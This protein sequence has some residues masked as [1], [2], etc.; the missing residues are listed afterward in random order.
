MTP[1]RRSTPKVTRYRRHTSRWHLMKLWAVVLFPAVL[2]A[3]NLVVVG[4]GLSRGEVK[5]LGRGIHRTTQYGADPGGFIA[6]ICVRT[7]FILLFTA[8]VVA[9]WRQAHTDSRI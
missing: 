2:A 7:F 1:R 6:N 4:L 8:V 5:T 3:Y 9:L